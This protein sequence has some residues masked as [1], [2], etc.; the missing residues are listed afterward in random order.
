VR[1]VRTATVAAWRVTE[2]DQT[3]SGETVVSVVRTVT[4]GH[5]RIGLSNGGTL[6]CAGEWRLSVVL[7]PAR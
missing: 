5:V 2:G 1:A 4:T 6:V 3:P 7:G